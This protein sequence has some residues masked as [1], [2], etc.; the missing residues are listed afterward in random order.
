MQKRLKKTINPF[1]LVALASASSSCITNVASFSNKVVTLPSETVEMWHYDSFSQGG[2]YST[3]PPENT[4]PTNLPNA[5]SQ[6]VLDAYARFFQSLLELS[7]NNEMVRLYTMDS[8]KAAINSKRFFKSSFIQYALQNINETG[9]QI[10]V[11]AIL[12]NYASAKRYDLSKIVSMCLTSK[13]LRLQ[14]SGMDLIAAHPSDKF[15]AKYRNLVFENAYLRKKWEVINKSHEL[16][17]S[18][19]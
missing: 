19:N 17:R 16:L 5:K 8:A 2:L 12:L 11:R 14:L 10:I 18:S 7:N 15:F 4:E 13:S 6:G 3:L 9:L 1:V